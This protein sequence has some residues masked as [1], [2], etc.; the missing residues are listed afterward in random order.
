MLGT[1]QHLAFVGGFFDYTES[2][3]LGQGAPTTYNEYLAYVKSNPGVD[4][5]YFTWDD[6]AGLTAWGNRVDASGGQITL[7]GHSYGAATAASAVADGLKV[8]TLVTLDPVSYIRP[9]FQNVA[10][11]IAPG[12]QWLNFVAAGGGLTLPN[13]IAGIGSAWNDATTGYAT[14][15]TNVS[16]D[17][18]GIENA[19]VYNQLLGVS[20]H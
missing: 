19:T 14:S 20:V 13:A 12:G 8:Q 9:D 18:G 10:A 17:H 2:L 1:P 4:V 11:N 7:I 3:L 15:T 6:K 5:Q 16:T